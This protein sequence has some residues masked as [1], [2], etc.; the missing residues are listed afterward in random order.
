M[1]A[2][3]IATHAGINN[4]LL[5]SVSFDR[6]D[7]SGVQ[8]RQS[9]EY[10]DLANPALYERSE[11][12]LAL[13]MTAFGRFDY[14]SDSLGDFRLEGGYQ[15]LDSGAEFQFN[16]VVTHRSRINL[17]NKWVAGHWNHKIDKLSF[18][19]YVGASQGAPKEE[20]RMFL[21]GNVDASYQ[22]RFDY[23]AVNALT[24]AT[25]EFGPWLQLDLGFDGELHEE[26]VLYWR[27]TFYR[28]AP[29]QEL[30]EERDG[31]ARDDLRS[32]TYRQ[33]GA[34]VQ[35]HSAPFPGLP[36][37]RLTGAARADWIDF[38]QD[39]YSA[40]T[41]VRGSIAY[42]FSPKLTAKLLGGRAFQTPSGTSL[43]MHQGY[44]NRQYI[45]G[46][47]NLDVPR[48]LRPQVVTSFELVATSQVSDFLS[49]EASG[50][51]QELEDAIRFNTGGVRVTA[52][53]SGRAST[54]GAE[55][56]AN[57]HL[58]RFR[59]YAVVSASKQ[60]DA[61]LSS[62]FDDTSSFDGSPSMFPRLFGYAGCD[63]ELL[64]EKLFLNGE[65][66]YAGPRGPSQAGY[67]GNNS[68]VYSLPAY[69]LVDLTLSTGGLPV[70]DRDLATRLLLS[71]RNV[72][73]KYYM[74]PGF[75]GVDIPQPGRTLLFE[76]RQNL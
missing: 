30:F 8:A 29:G 39:T 47:R 62:G 40:Q 9:F 60:I 75:A 1:G 3:A 2:S 32:L 7:R 49:L 64:T 54:A 35:A 11:E 53:N 66:W 20:Y 33:F 26:G 48:G 73:N 58:G 65:V 61:Q 37:F 6:F 59:P 56:I 76:I 19:S 70:L 4:S 21:T 38:E 25:Y 43:H 67:Y 63:V 51:Y 69:Q 45:F 46:T 42:R 10:Q 15:E 27:T 52:R 55:L 72:L 74:E 22:P 34:Y 31:I 16:S 13:P 41:S 68:T 23:T 57:M 17:E 71:V 12:D 28:E 24:E 50:F 5:L 44:S 36:D 14:H 18:Q